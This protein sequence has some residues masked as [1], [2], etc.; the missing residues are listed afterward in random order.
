MPSRAVDWLSLALRVCA[1]ILL[2]LTAFMLVP[3]PQLRAA[4]IDLALAATS[5]LPNGM[6]GLLVFATPLGTALRGDF[7]LCAA[8]IYLIDWCVGRACTPS[9]MR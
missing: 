8:G 9:R 3:L 2:V 5:L 6:A 1:G 7:L 4:Q